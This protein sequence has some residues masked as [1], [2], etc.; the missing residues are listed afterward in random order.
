MVRQHHSGHFRLGSSL[1]RASIVD[2]LRPEPNTSCIPPDQKPSCRPGNGLPA[3]TSM[4]TATAGLR[5]SGATY[6]KASYFLNH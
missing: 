5:F 3:V 1:P 2:P 6:T 4:E